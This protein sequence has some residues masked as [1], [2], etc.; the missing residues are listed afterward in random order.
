MVLDF[1]KAFDKVPHKRLTLQ[2]KYYG[3]SGPILPWLTAVL[4]DR[5]Q[6]VL[7]GP[8]SDTVSVSSGTHQGTVL[9]PLLFLLYINDL[10]LSTRNSSTRPL[11]D[12]SVLYRA[13]KTPGGCRLLQQDLDALQQWERTWQMHFRPDKC[14]IL[15]FTRSHNPIHHTYT[16]RDTQLESVQSHKYL[17][18]HLS[19]NVKFNTQ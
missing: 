5:T 15:R 19:T 18:V 7:D 16:L 2:L 4:T 13:V 17:G 3:I 10:P 1:A 11:E 6:R 8:S 12:D 14:K 9:G